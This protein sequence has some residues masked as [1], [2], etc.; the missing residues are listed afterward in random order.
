LGAYLYGNLAL[1]QAGDLDL[2]IK[3]QD[4]G[5]AR[6]ILLDRGYRP[7]HVLSHG[8][9][10]FMFQSRYSE[11][12][13]QS[14]GSI[15][16]LHW[17]FTNGDVGLPLDLEALG[18]GLQETQFGGGTL[19]MFGRDDL[20][21]ILCIHGSK[22]RWDR[23]EWLC[24]VAELLRVSSRDLDWKPL[25]DRASRLGT[26]RML[27]LGVLLAHDLLGAPVDAEFKQIAQSDHAVSRLVNEVPRLFLTDAVDGDGAGNLAT[28]LFRFRLRE[29][30]RDRLRFIW[31]RL[32]TPSHPESWSAV[33]VGN[34][35]FALHGFIRPFR[36]LSK[37]LPAIR[38]YRL[39]SRER[40]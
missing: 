10:E 20:L 40:S 33:S 13:E 18:S 38:Q 7:R 36:V 22:H 32:T 19:Q 28:D 15:V 12:F 14:D 30:R 6:A 8:G 11:E 24:G 3:R 37:L 2:L 17:A 5:R 23:L 35:W 1:R 25:L 29:R 9:E 27:L 39:A 31:Y 21:L 4:V 16:E 26:R 34:H